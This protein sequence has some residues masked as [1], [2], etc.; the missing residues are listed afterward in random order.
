MLGHI[1]SSTSSKLGRSVSTSDSYDID[2]TL[3]KKTD[4]KIR[5]SDSLLIHPAAEKDGE[6]KAL[7]DQA[8][9]SSIAR[10]SA[11]E[12]L[13]LIEKVEKLELNAKSATKQADKP[14]AKVIASATS[15]STSTV[16]CIAFNNGQSG[17]AKST[18]VKKS[19]VTF[20]AEKLASV[21]SRIDDVS[22]LVERLND[23]SALSDLSSSNLTNGDAKLERIEI[24]WH[25]AAKMV[26]SF[27]S[28][29][30]FSANVI[31]EVMQLEPFMQKELRQAVRNKIQ[32]MLDHIVD[33]VKQYAEL[34]V[35][36]EKE[37]LAALASLNN[38]RLITKNAGFISL[39][40]DNLIKILRALRSLLNNINKYEEICQE[41]L[42]ISASQVIAEIAV[43]IIKQPLNSEKFDRTLQR[44]FDYFKDLKEENNTY[45]AYR[46]AYAC[47]ALI[48]IY[49]QTRDK[50]FK[51]N[52]G[53]RA[54][55]AEK[56]VNED[57]AKQ[58]EELNISKAD[59]ASA[60]QST[61][62][63]RNKKSTSEKK[64]DK[65]FVDDLAET[66]G[67]QQTSSWYRSLRKLDRIITERVA[68]EVEAKD[69]EK[70]LERLDFPEKSL[71]RWGIFER[72]LNLLLNSR[73]KE[74]AWKEIFDS[75][76]RFSLDRKIQN[77]SLKVNQG[78]FKSVTLPADENFSWTMPIQ[79]EYSRQTLNNWIETQ[80]IAEASLEDSIVKFKALLLSI[81]IF[82]PATSN[83]LIQHGKKVVMAKQKAKRA[84]AKNNLQENPQKIEIQDSRLRFF[85]RLQWT[86]DRSVSNIASI[87]CVEGEDENRKV[88][89]LIAYSMNKGERGGNK[90]FFTLNDEGGLIPPT[91][92][93]HSEP[94]LVGTKQVGRYRIRGEE[95]RSL[96]E[97][98]EEYCASTNA[99]CVGGKQGQENC[100]EAL[101]PFLPRF[102]FAIDY[103]GSKSAKGFEDLNKSHIDQLTEGHKKN[104]KPGDESEEESEAE[105]DVFVINSRHF[106]KRDLRNTQDRKE[107]VPVERFH[108]ERNGKISE[109]RAVI[110]QYFYS[111]PNRRIF[112]DYAYPGKDSYRVSVVW[113]DNERILALDTLDTEVKSKA[114]PNS[115]VASKIEKTQQKFPKLAVA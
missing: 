82:T 108:T 79:E 94:V 78:V 59:K 97:V 113:E 52:R 19:T 17:K 77:R 44:L 33:G 15:L 100:K 10:V 20:T 96:K 106:H 89:Y 50:L 74:G 2:Q 105:Y 40:K 12:E 21:F 85:R 13:A 86:N 87:K 56:T 67:T 32:G 35:A 88:S 46:A 69:L 57:L 31:T 110:N 38:L 75:L 45:L 16:E 65:E 6:A 111:D 11:E 9:H 48:K 55:D 98:T 112:A 22:S 58:I 66:W 91:Y 4:T 93:K 101:V 70:Y 7:E 53:D 99:P 68:G 83:L 28:N 109:K 27:L 76:S 37:G 29:Q 107:P 49:A 54:N 103:D 39:E 3:Q 95:I 24:R 25:L 26:S 81:P 63:E 73:L 36:N 62:S 51:E 61:A 42:N 114:K 8:T 92:R 104:Q 80:S 72:R 102:S 60:T 115:S 71:A 5:N 18:V 47:Q 1:Q 34:K 41:Q 30:F 23:S 64:D 14:N 90:Y 43:Q 84:D